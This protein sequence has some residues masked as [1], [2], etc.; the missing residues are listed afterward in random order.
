[1]S[2]INSAIPKCKLVIFSKRQHMEKKNK[3]VNEMLLFHGTSDQICAQAIVRQNFDWRLS[4]KNGTAYGEGSYFAKDA[5]LSDKYTDR[6]EAKQRFMFLAR[7]LVGRCTKGAKG[8]KRPPPIDKSCP[9]DLYDSCVDN[10]SKPTMYVVFESD[11]CY[12]EYLICY[13]D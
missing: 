13:S 5:K 2:L 7:V 10:E 12:P 8:L 1:M 3:N 9:H 6:Q 11:Q 4:G